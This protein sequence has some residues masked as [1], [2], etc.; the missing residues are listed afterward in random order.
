MPRKPSYGRAWGATLLIF[1][2]A[3]AAAGLAARRGGAAAGAGA[4]PESGGAD[5][6][7][8][9]RVPEITAQYE[10]GVKVMEL[11]LG[12]WL[13]ALA[14][15]GW[16]PLPLSDALG[17]LKEGGGLPENSIVT[18]FSPGTLRTYEIAAPIFRRRRWPATWLADGRAVRLADRRYPTAHVLRLMRRRDGWD[19]G[20]AEASGAFRLKGPRAAARGGWLAKAGGLALNRAAAL[21]RLGCLV[22]N[23]DWTA[24]DLVR[25][26]AAEKPA[27]GKVC[28]GKAWIQSREWGVTMPGGSPE[29]R[30]SLRAPPAKKGARLFWLGTAGRPDFRLRARARGLEGEL[31]LLLRYDEA[32]GAGL[33]VALGGR[34]VVVEGLRGS[35]SR[36]LASLALPAAPQG[37]PFQLDIDLAGRRLAL[38]M[39]GSAPIIVDAGPRPAPGQGMLQL[40]LADRMRGIA[41]VRDLRL[42]FSPGKAR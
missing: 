22:V 16:R 8:V 39:D 21:D 24:A 18:V 7:F 4:D 42:D 29:A 31:R 1:A 17:R 23:G 37:R 13:D 27:T 38:S 12:Q 34:D 2:A 32:S 10:S 33:L 40:Q 6:F 41:E 15:A 19:A 30:F 5:W 28:L 36:R 9:L 25:R 26:L 35:R 20:F 11:R 14:R 3:A